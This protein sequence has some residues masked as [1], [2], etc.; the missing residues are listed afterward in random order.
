MTAFLRFANYFKKY[1]LSEFFRPSKHS[2]FTALW[3]PLEQKPRCNFS[4]APPTHFVQGDKI[5]FCPPYPPKNYIKSTFLPKIVLKI[6]F[7]LNVFKT[8]DT[9]ILIYCIYSH[10]N[11]YQ[12]PFTPI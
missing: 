4:G 5:N 3:R 2:I 9:V 12:L 11:H 10:Y 6:P 7:T 1:A 8:F